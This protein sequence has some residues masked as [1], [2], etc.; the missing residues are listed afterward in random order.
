MNDFEHILDDCVERLTKGTST[1]EECLSSHPQ[2]AAQLRPLLQSAAGL[3]HHRQDT[4]ISPTARARG[5]AKLT[6]HMKEHPRQR[7]KNFLFFPRLAIG[8]AVLMFALLSVGTVRAQSAL[9][10]DLFYSWKLASERV[11]RGISF[12]TNHV[13]LV[14]ADRRVSEI[15]ATTD[16]PTRRATV[17]RDYQ[18]ILL[19]LE[20]SSDADK[21][22]LLSTLEIHQ[23]SL[24]DAGLTV[25]ELDNY[26]SPQVEDGEKSP[27]EL[28]QLPVEV[29]PAIE[30]PSLHP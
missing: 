6:L 15:V 12:D 16:D 19:R 18:E 30:I 27:V 22:Q 3:V 24:K 10:S 11:W 1:L 29:A 5:R 4:T 9:P 25:P 13:D 8:V 7:E 20:A 17:L 28:P 26:L 14:L 21:G 23:K 2:Y